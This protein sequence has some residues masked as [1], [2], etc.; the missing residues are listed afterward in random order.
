MAGAVSKKTWIRV[1]GSHTGGGGGEIVLANVPI[2]GWIR[3]VRVA[4]T[5]NLTASIAEAS[6]PGTFGV[7][8]AYGS[9]ATP[10]D[11]EEDPGIFYQVDPTVT[12][13]S[14]GTLYAD[15]TTS[16]SGTAIN[17]QIDIEPAN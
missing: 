12:A 11:Q 17:I 15:V 2:R 1:S 14:V 16:N 4:G 13:G 10:I 9:T 7:V 3:R 5:D 6:S 8:L